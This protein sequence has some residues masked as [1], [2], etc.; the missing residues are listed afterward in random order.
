MRRSAIRT[1]RLRQT[2]RVN[3]L[4]ARYPSPGPLAKREKPRAHDVRQGFLPANDEIA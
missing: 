1:A 2:V 3:E 4:V